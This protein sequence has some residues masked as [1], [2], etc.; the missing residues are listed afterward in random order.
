[1]LLSIVILNYKTLGLIKNC[2]KAIKELNWNFSYEIIIVDNC[3]NDGS[4][5]YIKENLFEVKL[6]ESPKNLGFGGG[7][8]LGIKEAQGKYVMVL[9][10]DILILNNAVDKMIAFMEKNLSAG[11]V[12]PKL[13]NPDGSLQYSCS[14]F[15]DWYLPFYRRTILSN[16]KK[17]KKWVDHYLMK[18]WD[19]QS[20]QK[21]DWLYGACLLVR[22]SALEKVGLFDQENYFMYME[23]LDWCRRFWENNYEVWYLSE[24]EVIHFHQ[25]DSADSSG[26]TGIFK[27]SGR[28]H[29]K[30]F[31]KYC[32]KFRGKPLPRKGLE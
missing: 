17:G 4:A 31:L 11:L 20:N 7:N 16:T 22:Q 12:G 26:I 14:R 27:K 5:E 3:S 9:N 23:D 19:H 28:I 10:P 13:L 29:L 15:P 6:I 18:D 2:L 1:M 21:V 32:L 30:S 25:R 24:A 8:N